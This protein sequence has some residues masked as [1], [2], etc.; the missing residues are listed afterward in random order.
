MINC[1]FEFSY[2]GTPDVLF[3]K[4]KTAIE[5]ERGQ[6]EGDAESGTIKIPYALFSVQGNYKIQEQSI[7]IEI[8]KKPPLTSCERIEN[9]IT[10]F[11]S[12]DE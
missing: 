10:S 3:Q 4:I 7:R 9:S 12:S 6:V 1:S 11:L 2:S 5:A 8:T